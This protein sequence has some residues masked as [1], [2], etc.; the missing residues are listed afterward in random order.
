MGVIKNNSIVLS[1]ACMVSEIM[2]KGRTI[3]E[4]FF[5]AVFSIAGWKN[6]FRDAFSMSI[7]TCKPEKIFFFWIVW[8]G[9]GWVEAWPRSGRRHVNSETGKTERGP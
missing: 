9:R 6:V 2:N 5:H 4:A 1:I 3:N 7:I 8:W